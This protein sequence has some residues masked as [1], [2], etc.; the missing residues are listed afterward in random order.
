MIR[1]VSPAVDGAIHTGNNEYTSTK[2]ESPNLG[3]YPNHTHQMTT[4]SGQTLHDPATTNWSHINNTSNTSGSSTPYPFTH[5]NFYK[6]TSNQDINGPLSTLYSG[7]SASLDP[8]MLT[9]HDHPFQSQSDVTLLSSSE[10]IRRVSDSAHSYNAVHSP[11]DL[12]DQYNNRGAN[13]GPEAD[14]NSF[15][16]YPAYDGLVTTKTRI[17]P[18]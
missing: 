4:V 5:N 12:P 3:T 18:Y 16:D 13:P 6:T 7:W 17:S 9:D 1:K 8:R 2:S 14:M 15:F 11:P 10:G